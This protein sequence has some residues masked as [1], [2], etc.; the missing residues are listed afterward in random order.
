MKK[1]TLGSAS[2]ATTKSP[3]GIN[4]LFFVPIALVSVIIYAAKKQIQWKK[5][6]TISLFGMAGAVIG[7]MC[8]SY[9][10]GKITAKIT[11]SGGG[12]ATLRIYNPE[13][14]E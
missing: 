10:G 9:L 11:L 5:T 2:T 8:A 7:L 3:Q 12:V 13:N 14:D 6:I 1:T 4:L